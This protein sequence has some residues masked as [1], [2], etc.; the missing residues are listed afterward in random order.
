MNKDI[1]ILAKTIYGEADHHNL[2]EME[3]IAN[4]VLNRER[5]A[6][7][8]INDWWGNTISQICLKPAQFACW[9]ATSDNKEIKSDNTIYQICH[10]IAVRAVKGLL[11]DNT[12]GGL[13]Y[14]NI[15][16]HPKWA[17][18]GVP[19]AK[20]GRLLFYDII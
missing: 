5:L 14:H 12:N 7:N 15:D 20:I 13:Y 3:A 10:R 16:E 4:V 1:Q 19:C 18:A 9:Q 11:Q 6:Q 2:S 17:Y 8:G